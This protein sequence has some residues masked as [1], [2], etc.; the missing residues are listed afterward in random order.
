MLSSC[1]SISS[2]F[3]MKHRELMITRQVNEVEPKDSGIVAGRVISRIIT[4]KNLPLTSA[5]LLMSAEVMAEVDGILRPAIL[6]RIPAG[7]VRGMRKEDYG[8]FNKSALA[9][10]TLWDSLKGTE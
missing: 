1:Q 6:D 9:A 5:S 10:S 4:G 7:I 2:F 3:P 8:L